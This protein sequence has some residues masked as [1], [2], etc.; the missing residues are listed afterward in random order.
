[1][2]VSPDDVKYVINTHMHHDHLGGNKFFTKAKHIVQREEYRF[3]ICPDE[4]FSSRYCLNT[5]LPGDPLDWQLLEGEAE[6]LPGIVLIPTPGH[7]PGHQSVFFRDI[8]GVGPL[9]YTGDS[10][11]LEENWIK[12]IGPGICWN[13]PLAVQ[14]MKKLQQI[15]ALTGAYVFFSHDW[16][17]F[18]SVP[19]APKKFSK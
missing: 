9:I 18:Y 10:V 12:T 5:D 14:S 3:A 7:S 13:P 15:A 4:S 6:P 17:F 16:E 1:M 11:Y 19:L 2:G 8:P